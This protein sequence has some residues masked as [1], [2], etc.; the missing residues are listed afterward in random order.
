LEHIYFENFLNIEDSADLQKELEK[1]LEK[2]YIP[3][4]RFN[5]DE[6]HIDQL[7]S[8][9]RN[10]IE[11]QCK[12]TD[13]IHTPLTYMFAELITNI[14][15]HSECKNGYIFSQFLPGKRC[16]NV[17]IADDGITVL[18]SY[19]E[20]S[21]YKSLVGDDAGKALKLANEGKST[22]G[23]DQRGFGLSTTRKML[24]KGLG[25]AFFMMSANAFYRCDNG[26]KE[27]VKTLPE[28]YFWDGTVIL[29]KI[30]VDI[31][32]D[33]DYTKYLK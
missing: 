31:P 33:F 25:G 16:L 20:D 12:A 6:K 32:E 8:I 19:R 21:R 26:D 18:G 29:V 30:P 22:K 9:I 5:P 28:E 13:R 17:C 10:I 27:I 3:L 23:E 1:Y 24:V 4:C 2:S 7:Q 11:K 14:K 15:D